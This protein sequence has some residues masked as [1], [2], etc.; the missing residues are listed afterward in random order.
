[1]LRES[2]YLFVLLAVL[3]SFALQYDPKP[4]PKS[5]VEVERARF[6]VITSHLI[7]MEWGATIDAAT[8]TFIN[9]NLPTPEFTTSRDGDWTVIQTAAV[10]VGLK[11]FNSYFISSMDP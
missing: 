3:G 7:R 5:I 9:R 10:K 2:G 8:F 6:T 1:M 4:N 11:C